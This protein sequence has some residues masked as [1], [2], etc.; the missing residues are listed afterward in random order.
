MEGVKPTP[1]AKEVVLSVYFYYKGRR[2]DIDNLVKAVMDGLNSIGYED[3]NQVGELHIK[4]LPDPANP[5]AVV[6][7]EEIVETA[8]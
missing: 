2:P 7:V 1:K 8:K 4:R 6:T 5:R 3:D